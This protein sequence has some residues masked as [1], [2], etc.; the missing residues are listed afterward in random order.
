[1][2]PKPAEALVLGFDFMNLF[3]P[4]I[5]GI[6]LKPAF[7]GTVKQLDFSGGPQAD[8]FQGFRVGTENPGLISAVMFF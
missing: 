8:I 2:L 3:G 7:Q 6:F 4:L 5:Q 1:M